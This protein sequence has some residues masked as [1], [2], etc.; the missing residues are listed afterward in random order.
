M[1]IPSRY[2]HPS[3]DVM[4][5]AMSKLGGHRIGHNEENAIPANENPRQITQ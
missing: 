2:V 4:F 5:A 3:E 1:G